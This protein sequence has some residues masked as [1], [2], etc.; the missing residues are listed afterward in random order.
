MSP[1]VNMMA[2]TATAGKQLHRE[3]SMLIEIHNE[4]VVAR[5]PSRM[6]IAYSIVSFYLL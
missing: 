4:V 1:S 2:L 5:V 6:N 3:V